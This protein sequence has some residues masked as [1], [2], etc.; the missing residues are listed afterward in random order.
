M[1]MTVV[2]LCLILSRVAISGPLP[3]P[4]CTE[5]LDY[6]NRGRL[7]ELVKLPQSFPPD[8][9]SYAFGEIGANDTPP[10]FLGVVHDKAANSDFEFFNVP[11]GL[12]YVFDSKHQPIVFDRVT[13]VELE[14]SIGSAI[15]MLYR[16][17]VAHMVYANGNRLAYISRIDAGPKE[18]L[19]CRFAQREPATTRVIAGKS[20]VCDA[21]AAKQVDYVIFSG[22]HFLTNKNF[23]E[24]LGLRP[25][26]ILPGV[27]SIDL[28]GDGS[29]DQIGGYV[30]LE[31][32]SNCGYVRLVQLD[33]TH[34][35]LV[36]SR[37]QDALGEVR[38][39]CGEPRLFRFQGHSYIETSFVR[40]L[41]K[42]R[43]VNRIRRGK[44]ERM[45]ELAELAEN[46]VVAP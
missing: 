44:V 22:K 39:D 26:D 11:D 45:C 42:G 30:M 16:R 18:T 5:V 10:Q 17:G 6:A 35:S 23:E 15:G 2:V 9:E 13:S 46:I 3:P 1:R 20:S 27:G 19:L 34:K 37:L 41:I 14:N 12:F 24:R 8:L 40:R 29:D 25:S 21:V 33:E 4:I 31:R 28:D 32:E 7:D 36:Q 43:A 38:G